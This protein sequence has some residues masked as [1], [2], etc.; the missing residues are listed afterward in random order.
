MNK[1]KIAIILMAALIT[2]LS[3]TS[4]KALADE[5]SVNQTSTVENTSVNGVKEAIVS[6]FNLHNSNNFDSYNESF[7]MDNKNIASITNN[8]GNYQGS[9]IDKA[10][11]GNFQTHWE[12]GKENS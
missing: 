1:K 7:K 4:V 2:N 6:K 12:T 9:T 3:S 11:D 5:I 10:I 8:G